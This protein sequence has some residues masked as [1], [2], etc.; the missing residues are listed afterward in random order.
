M[1]YIVEVTVLRP[2]FGR[3]LRPRFG[4]GAPPFVHIEPHEEAPEGVFDV[5]RLAMIAVGVVGEGR[6]AIT[7]Q[8]GQRD[9]LSQVQSFL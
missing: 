2:A 6:P 4:R 1:R 9:D 3:A 8:C 5:Y 7:H